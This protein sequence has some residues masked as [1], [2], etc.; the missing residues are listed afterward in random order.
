MKDGLICNVVRCL[1][2]DEWGNIW[3]STGNGLSMLS[4]GTMQF[5]NYS[6]EQGLLSSQ[7][8]L[9]A[10]CVCADGSLCFGTVDGL[11]VIE[12]SRNS[13]QYPPLNLHVTKTSVT[14]DKYG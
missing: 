12:P 5:L 7:F 13:Y 11:S 3:I 2:E 8:Y 1:E 9:N 14:G 4:P 6:V 10:S